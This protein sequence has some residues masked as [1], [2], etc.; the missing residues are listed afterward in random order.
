MD[1]RLGVES[2]ED[3]AVES[4]PPHGLDR[5]LP[6]VPHRG[7]KRQLRRGVDRRGREEEL[8]RFAAPRL[9]VLVRGAYGPPAPAVGHMPPECVVDPGRLG[10]CTALARIVVLQTTPEAMAPVPEAEPVS[11]VRVGVQIDRGVPREPAD[12]GRRVRERPV[13]P[14]VG[15]AREAEARPGEEPGRA[16]VCGTRGR[17][18]GDLSGGVAGGAAG[19]GGR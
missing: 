7:G 11:V 13:G 18:A 14:A 17:G 3:A 9:E 8:L 4:R 19:R 6:H 5:S 2:I 10:P 16:G 15:E 1:L 12:R